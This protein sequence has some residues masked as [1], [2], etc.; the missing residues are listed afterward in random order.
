[1]NPEFFKGTSKY[2]RL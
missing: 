2:V 1:M